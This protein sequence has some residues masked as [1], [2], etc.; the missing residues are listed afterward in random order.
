MKN[1]EEIKKLSVYEHLDEPHSY[2][3]IYPNAPV[4]S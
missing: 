1:I 4:T 3:Y 2:E